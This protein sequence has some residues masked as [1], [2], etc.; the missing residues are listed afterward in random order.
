MSNKIHLKCGL[1]GM[2]LFFFGMLGIAVLLAIGIPLLSKIGG[3]A[4]IVSRPIPL[5]LFLLLGFGT[6]YWV[7]R[8]TIDYLGNENRE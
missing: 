1:W 4:E 3:I 7:S 2:G 5:I 6:S 8:K